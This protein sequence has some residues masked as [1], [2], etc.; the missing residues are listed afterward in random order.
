MASFLFCEKIN[1]SAE[2]RACACAGTSERGKGVSVL[3]AGRPKKMNKKTLAS[4]VEKYFKSISRT[5]TVKGLDGYPILNDDG[6]EMKVIS[7]VVPPSIE[8]LC[9][10]I[11]IEDRTWRNY[12]DEEKHPDLAPITRY[13]K[14][15]CQAYLVEQLNSREKVQGI[16]FNLQN[17]YGWREKKE[18]ELG[19]E[20]RKAVPAAMTMNEKLEILA[21]AQAAIT[22][23]GLSPEA[24]GDEND[25]ESND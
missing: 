3:G 14:Q 7:Y 20:T 1:I 18:V 19:S 10:Y 23:H 17:N 4:G 15:R 8:A 6:E 22:A 11:G 24:S 5:I 25:E 12:S 13:A 21:K 16:I 2:Q 9:L